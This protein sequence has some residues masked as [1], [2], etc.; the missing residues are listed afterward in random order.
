MNYYKICNFKCQKYPCSRKKSYIVF[1]ISTL[2]FSIWTRKT[3]SVQ[4]GEAGLESQL[5][6]PQYL[7]CP[8]HLPVSQVAAVQEAPAC[9][10]CC[11]LPLGSR[12][13]ELLPGCALRRLQSDYL[14]ST[15]CWVPACLPGLGQIEQACLWDTAALTCPARG[16]Q[17]TDGSLACPSL[18][19][20]Q[21]ADA[22]RPSAAGSLRVN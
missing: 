4:K 21:P 16:R 1:F 17:G 5:L 8:G 15:A 3:R 2:T 9:P 18:P 20:C 12:A 11:S 10:G 22:S 6:I 13:A 7:I 19:F 14:E